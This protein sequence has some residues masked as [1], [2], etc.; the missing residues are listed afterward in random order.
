MQEY[1]NSKLEEIYD[2]LFATIACHSSYR[3]GDK[4]NR[5]DIDFLIS[6][7]FKTE[8]PYSCPH[9]RPVLWELTKYELE[10]KF[11]RVG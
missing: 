9:G 4:M 11:G 5:N 1:K 8:K 2:R 3:G 7:L 6:E 10:K